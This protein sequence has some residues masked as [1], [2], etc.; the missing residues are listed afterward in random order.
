M[1]VKQFKRE[2]PL[3]MMLLLPVLFVLVFSYGSMAGIIMAFQDYIPGKG[4][5]VFGSPFIGLENFKQLIDLE[6]WSVLW[7]TVYIAGLKII[8][9]LVVP[10]MLAILLN[11][12]RHTW[13]KRG[14]QTAIFLPYFISWVIMAGMLV[15]ILSPSTGVFA[16]IADFFGTECPFFLGDNK[17]FPWVLVLSNLWKDAGYGVIVYLAAVTN[18]DPSLYEAATIDGAGYIKKTLHVTLP[19]ITPVIVL[20]TILSLGNI[21]NAGFDQVYNLYSPA[22]YQSGDIIDTF[23]YRLGIS[24][25]Q[26]SLS[27]AVG[28]FKSVVSFLFISGSYG[29]AYKCF[30]YRIF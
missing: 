21:L 23:V 9:G 28:L 29:I 5:Y 15:D 2:L 27:A 13:F 7:N 22:V 1:T 25:G 10:V 19:G 3:H 16:R 6:P 26:Y 11:E 12:V 20:M 30:D 14:V 18:I 24:E 17:W 8:T 4:F